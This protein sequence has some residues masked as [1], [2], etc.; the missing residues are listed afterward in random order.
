[1]G[2]ELPRELEDTLARFL[3]RLKTPRVLQFDV[4]TRRLLAQALA[5]VRAQWQDGGTPILLVALVG[6]TGVG[7]SSLINALAGAAI[8]PVGE[9]RPTTTTLYVYHHRAVTGNILPPELRQEAVLVPHD[10][11]ELRTKVL[12]DTPD[13]D[14]FARAHRDQTRALLKAAGLVLYVFSPEKYLDER[15]WSV[16]REEQRFSASAAVLNKTDQIAS[17]EELACIT[18]DLRRSLAATGLG[19]IRLFCTSATAHASGQEDE[20]PP[21]PP[22]DDTEALQAFLE[23]ELSESD[24]A[25]LR[26]TQYAQVVA[27]L[28]DVVNQLVPEDLLVRCD[29]VAATARQQ[30]AAA[31]TDLTRALRDPLTVV[32]RELAPLVVVGQHDRF[33]GPFRTWLAIADFLRFGLPRAVRQ[34]VSSH[35]RDTH[36]TLAH[37]LS[38]GPEQQVEDLLRRQ[39]R[40]IQDLLY[41]AGLPVERWRTITADWE[42]QQLLTE[43]AAALEA[44]FDTTTYT[45]WRTRRVVVWLVNILG[46]CVPTVLVLYGLYALARD[47]LAGTYEGLAVLAHVLAIG[48]LFF[49]LLQGVVGVLLPAPRRLGLDLGQQAIHTVL[50]R[51]IDHGLNVYRADLHADLEDFRQPL[52][53]LHAEPLP[54]LVSSQHALG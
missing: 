34:L 40:S 24:V 22:V 15:T 31:A 10:R 39:A 26:Q 25:R 1:M 43:I 38:H 11:P 41:A 8:A 18:A 30:S 35:R 53:S 29:E 13:L 54:V 27:Y 33:R 47:F 23:R 6:G 14:S 4:D 49:V 32:E 48:G 28:Q 9:I 7:K 19:E 52:A 37:L 44:A 12:I 45:S 5:R 51:V 17:A 3:T 2:T 21:M 36:G 42:S 46:T 20:L 16:L 50:L